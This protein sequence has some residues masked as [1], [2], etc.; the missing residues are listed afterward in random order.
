MRKHELIQVIAQ[1]SGYS[2]NTVTKVMKGT[3]TR[4]QTKIDILNTAI[5]LKK[6]KT[7][8]LNK[9]NNKLQ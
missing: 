1:R 7:D 4:S 9:L 5:A 6:E 3:K 8:E 2:R